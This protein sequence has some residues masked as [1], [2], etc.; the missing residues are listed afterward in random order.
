MIKYR[1][2]QLVI[3]G[4][5]ACNWKIAERSGRRR[6]SRGEAKPR[7]PNTTKR[8]AQRVHLPSVSG[9]VGEGAAGSEVRQ[10]RGGVDDA[11]SSTRRA[12]GIGG[13]IGCIRGDLDAVVPYG[14]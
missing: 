2:N 8:V 13:Q 7:G 4:N 14:P 1:G 5:V 12:V 10:A 9:V 6:S 11:G 3:V